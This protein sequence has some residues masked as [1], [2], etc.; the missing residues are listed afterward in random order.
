MD[1][2]Q[3]RNLTILFIV[4]NV[5]IWPFFIFPNIGKVVHQVISNISDDGSGSMVK[6]TRSQEEM[7]NPIDFHSMRDPF[8]IP[9]GVR[10]KQDNTVKKTV[11][12]TTTVQNSQSTPQYNVDPVQK[13]FVSRFK[14]KSIVKVN[15][16]YY[17]NL[18]ESQHYGDQNSSGVPYSYRFGPDGQPI[19]SSSSKSFMVVQNDSVMGETA[20]KIMEDYVIMAKNRKYYKLTFSGG[21]EVSSP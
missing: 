7:L 11:K 4:V 1:E 12:K 8:L 20:V 15:S 14:L 3:K 17:A 19:T 10:P 18:E 13:P 2:K 9:N 16:V 21:Y 5:V 6:D